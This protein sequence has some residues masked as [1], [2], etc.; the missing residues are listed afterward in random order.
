M[1]EFRQAWI[2][3][4]S[5]LEFVCKR[6]IIDKI[7]EHQLNGQENQNISAGFCSGAYSDVKCFNRGFLHLNLEF[8]PKTG[9]L[10]P[11]IS[12][13]FDISY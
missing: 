1:S 8:K 9:F 10:K 5:K 12:V 13:F 4:A 11:P 6:S 7:I 2:P 3:Q